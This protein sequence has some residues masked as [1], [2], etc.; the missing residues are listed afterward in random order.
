MQCS[1]H[2]SRNR[3]GACFFVTFSVQNEKRVKVATD[4]RQVGMFVVPNREAKTNE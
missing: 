1:R 2:C 4:D 3:D